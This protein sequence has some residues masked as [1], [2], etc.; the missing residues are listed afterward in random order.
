[1]YMNNNIFNH[2]VRTLTCSFSE[3]KIYPG[4][5]GMYI[6]KDGQVSKLYLIYLLSLSTIFL[7]SVVH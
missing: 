4:H 7:T 5:G 6:R 2:F 1:M 3:Y